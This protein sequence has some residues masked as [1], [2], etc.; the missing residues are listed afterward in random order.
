MNGPLTTTKIA[1][2]IFQIIGSVDVIF[3]IYSLAKI[4]LK[5]KF[6]CSHVVVTSMGMTAALQSRKSLHLHGMSIPF[7]H[8]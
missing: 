4:R 8:A 2:P 5:T 1:L 3:C 6:I 7:F